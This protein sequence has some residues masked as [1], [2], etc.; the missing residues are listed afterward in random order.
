M[1]IFHPAHSL[2]SKSPAAAGR[3]GPLNIQKSIRIRPGFERKLPGGG[4]G[5]LN[6][7]LLGLNRLLGVE[8][9]GG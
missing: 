9:A 7:Q 8:E 1:Y 2:S 6:S 5:G 4:G 3:R